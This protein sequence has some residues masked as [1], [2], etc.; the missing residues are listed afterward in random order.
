MGFDPGYSYIRKHKGGFQWY[1]IESEEIILHKSFKLK[2]VAWSLVSINGQ[3]TTWSINHRS[4]FLLIIAKE[5]NKTTIA[6]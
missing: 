4:F 2:I 5:I 3:S 1:N 6:F